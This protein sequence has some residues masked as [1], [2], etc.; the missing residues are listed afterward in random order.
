M[1]SSTTGAGPSVPVTNGHSTVVPSSGIEIWS[2]PP[3]SQGTV[4]EWSEMP[5]RIYPAEGKSDGT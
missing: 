2:V 3:K 4:P 5:V 1:S